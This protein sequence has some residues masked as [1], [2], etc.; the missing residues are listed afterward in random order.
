MKRFIPVLLSLLILFFGPKSFSQSDTSALKSIY[1]RVIDFDES[2]TDSVLFYAYYIKEQSIRLHFNKGDI[3]SLRLKG[4]YNEF[5]NEY[6]SA[7]N[8]YY[9]C[10]EESKRL[11]SDEYEAAALGDLAMAYNNINQPE[12]T[13]EFY[14][15]ALEVSMRRKEVSSIFTN[16]SNL[17]SI[18]NKLRQPDS[19]LFYLK[20]AEELAKKYKINFQLGSLYNNIGNAW[21]NKK[22]WDEALK[23]FKLNYF[24]DL[25][26]N[27][28]EM[29]WY[30]CFNICEV[31]IEKKMF[32]SAQKYLGS[33]KQLAAALT[34]KRKEADVYSLYARYYSSL[35]Q[36]KPAYDNLVKWHE[37][38]TALVSQ[39]TLSTVAEL[40]ERFNMKQK[41]QQNQLLSFEIDKQKSEKRNMALLVVGVALLA[42]SALTV[43]VLI[44]RKNEQLQKQNKLIQKQNEKLSGFNTEKNALISIV[45]HDLNA[46]F[47]SIKMWTNIL[48]SDISNFTE[49]QKKTLYRIQSSADNGEL[50]VRNILR[51]EKEEIN[52]PLNLE[53]LNVSAFLEDV[54]NIHEPQAQQKDMKI[55]YQSGGKL[56]E[57]MCDRYMLRRICEN[58]LSN[59]IKFSQRGKQVYV[60][61]ENRLDNI[62]ISVTDEG[63]GIAPEDIPYIFSKYGKISSMPTEG[64]YS[65][66]LGLS[67]VKRLVEELNGKIYCESQLGKGST[68]TVELPK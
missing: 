18:Y 32:D 15:H 12:K 16:S 17:G 30:D 5:R 8:Y 62:K 1:D 3:L 4:I 56:V 51:I 34:S 66:G 9:R 52:R 45:S 19:A 49:D 57:F 24:A 54:I 36:Y 47:T 33:S 25:A 21:F 43:L 14:R 59:A 7:I 38:D 61:L 41:D 40:Q 37:M 46:P 39:Q 29:L 60:S 50:L 53:F 35:N 31:Y 27:D 58:L 55:I 42:V 26:S 13:K 48:Q 68:F 23:F 28:K 10:L 63:V 65:T 64:E 6:D 20:Q 67:I 22:E 2:K 44:K 11:K